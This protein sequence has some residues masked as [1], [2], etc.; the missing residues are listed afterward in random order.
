MDPKY[1]P[2]ST[3]GSLQQYWI[4][5][6]IEQCLSMFCFLLVQR[7]EARLELQAREEHLLFLCIS[8]M[9]AYVLES[10]IIKNKKKAPLSP[11]P[12]AQLSIYSEL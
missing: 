11:T 9:L 6:S 4:K 12:P 10:K 7:K 8:G 1:A 3:W 2:V 5:Y